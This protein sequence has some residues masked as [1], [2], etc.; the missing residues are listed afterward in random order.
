MI[1][2]VNVKAPEVTYN[3]LVSAFLPTVIM[4]VWA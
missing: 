3:A 4:F 2:L 1:T